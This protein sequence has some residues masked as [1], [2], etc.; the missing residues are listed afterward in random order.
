MTDHEAKEILSLYRPG[1]ADSA[2]PDFAEALALCERDP[3]LKKWFDHH[4]ALY[5]ALRAKFKAIAVPEGLK[6]QIIA[7]RPIHRTPV[8]QRAVI[9]AGAVAAVFMILSTYNQWRPH[10]DPSDFAAY[11]NYMVGFATRGGGYAMDI[12]SHDPKQIRS[13]FTGKNAI[14]DYAVPANLQKNARLEGC[15]SFTWHGKNVSMICYSSG[16]PLDPG[17]A[18][19]VW[20]FVTDHTTTPDMP[21]ANSTK[22]DKVNGQDGL[23]TA[24][25]TAE[26]KTYVLATRGDEPFLN[27]Y[28]GD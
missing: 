14:A 2:D 17:Q 23:I 21:T 4:C 25:W 15:A 20:L 8:W 1:T 16:R 22:F 19:D 6:E 13:Y 18:S 12:R 5:L 28:L 3:E 11:R 9:L 26:N 10:S 24:S 27:K 7:E